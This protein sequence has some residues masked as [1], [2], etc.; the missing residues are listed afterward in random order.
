[1]KNAK[2]RLL[3]IFKPSNRTRLH[4]QSILWYACIPKIAATVFKWKIRLRLIIRNFT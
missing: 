4:V 3:I 2:I 1:M